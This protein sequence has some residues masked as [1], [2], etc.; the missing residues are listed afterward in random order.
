MMRRL[1][2]WPL[3]LAALAPVPGRAAET[4]EVR[5]GAV[6]T[7]DLSSETSDRRRPVLLAVAVL[8]GLIVVLR[9]RRRTSQ[10]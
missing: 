2:A 5:P 1:A 9:L 8:T 10:T 6:T 7:V 4:L 3:A